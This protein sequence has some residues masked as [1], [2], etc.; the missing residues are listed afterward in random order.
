MAAFDCTGDGLPELYVAGG[1]NPA[2]LFRNESQPGGAL[3]VHADHESRHRPDRRRGRL[4]RGYRR[5]RPDGPRASSRSTARTF[6]AVSA[7]AGSSPPT[8]ALGFDGRHRLDDRFSRHVGGRRRAADARARAPTSSSTPTATPRSTCD[9]S[10]L[11]RP[12]A[13]RARAMGQPVSLCTRLLHALDA[14]L[15]LGPV[16]PSR[17]AGHQ[18]PPL[19]RRRAGPAVA[20]RGRAAPA[21]LHGRRGLDAR[22]RSGAWGSPATT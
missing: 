1:T 21:R 20:D 22:C 10:S 17:P 3:A 5:R 12:A 6:S 7:A 9:T 19:L 15:R 16:R 18:R 8:R 4:S 14:V 2:A 13:R 11:V